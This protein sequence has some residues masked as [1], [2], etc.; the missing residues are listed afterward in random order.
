MSN[1]NLV[2]ALV[3]FGSILMFAGVRARVLVAQQIGDTPAI[4]THLDERDIESGRVSFPE[5]VEHGRR[6][7]TAVYNKLDGQGRP[8]DSLLMARPNGPDAHSC[9]SCHNRPRAGGGRGRCSGS[10]RGG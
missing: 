8:N 2:T 9:T 7:F 1:S 3:T 10:S 4:T 5:V 6:L